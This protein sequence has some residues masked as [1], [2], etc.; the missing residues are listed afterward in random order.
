MSTSGSI[1]CVIL[2]RGGSKRIPLKN[3]VVIKGLPLIAWSVI[4]ATESLLVDEVFVSTDN[5]E[6]TNVAKKYGAKIIERPAEFAGD[7]STSESAL[8]HALEYAELHGKVQA[9]VFLQP[10]SPVRT[11]SD[12]D[13]AV[14]LYLESRCDSLFS[15]CKVE[16]FV[17]RS[18]TSGLQPVN[19]R[20]SQRPMNQDIKEFLFEENGSI[21]V[22]APE[23][24]RKYNSRIGENPVVYEMPQWRSYQFDEHSDLEILSLFLEKIQWENV[25]RLLPNRISLIVYDFDGVLTD[26]KVVV[27]EEGSESVICSRSDSLGTDLI[28][29]LGIQQ[30]ILSTETSAVVRKRAKKLKVDCIAGCKNKKRQ[31][32]RFCKELKIDTQSVVYVGNDLNDLD[33]MRVVGCS[34]APFDAHK[35]VK[36][37]ATVIL[38]SEGGKGVVRELAEVLSY[39]KSNSRHSECKEVQEQ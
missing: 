14:K 22:F 31:L 3:L 19:Y 4:Q 2:A 12:I 6:I 1:I 38:G 15:A 27:G 34:V 20:P 24:L 23:T 30:L 32:F 7:K 13:N 8:L 35:Q 39:G 26:N 21:Y 36:S 5:D 33:V 17:W 16:G 37:I 10:T 18:S 25:G 11:R 28:R 9:V 29:G